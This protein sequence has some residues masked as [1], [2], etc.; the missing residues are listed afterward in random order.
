MIRVSYSAWLSWSDQDRAAMLQ[1]L[2][3][4]KWYFDLDQKPPKEREFEEYEGE[5]GDRGT[6]HR[7]F[8]PPGKM[9]LSRKS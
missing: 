2:E 3:G 8:T 7:G 9:Q 4:K 5:S 1:W 6:D